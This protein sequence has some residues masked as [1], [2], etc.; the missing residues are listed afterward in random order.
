MTWVYTAIRDRAL[1]A[2]LFYIFQWLLAHFD[3]NVSLPFI[4]GT[5]FDINVTYH[6]SLSGHL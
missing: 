1:K 4:V 5:V 2:G 3:L 6:K